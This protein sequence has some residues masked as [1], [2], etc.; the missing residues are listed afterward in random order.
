ML[1]KIRC[2]YWKRRDEGKGKQTIV[3]VC[4]ICVSILSVLG[5]G[6]R[7]IVSS[8]YQQEQETIE[9]D[10]GAD[11]VTGASIEAED[12]MPEENTLEE[13]ADIDTST[14][15]DD[16]ANIDISGVESFLG[17]MSDTAYMSMTKQLLTECETRQCTSAKKLDYQQTD[18]NS[19]DVTSFIVLSDGF[20]YRCD[21][22]LKSDIVSISPTNYSEKDIEA[23]HQSEIRAEQEKLKQQ[24]ERNRKEKEQ[25][26][27]KKKVKKENLKKK[28]KKFSNKKKK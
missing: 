4:I 12:V 23:M 18:E 14:H 22:N 24:Q 21:Y 2:I 15:A 16:L 19:F 1:K 10:A 8:S 11:V 25:A 27:K 5:L 13:H 28:S 9:K 7:N 20:I 6:V 26:A 17:F 3:A